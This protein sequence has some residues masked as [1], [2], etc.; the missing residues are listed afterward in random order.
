MTRTRRFSL[1][2]IVALAFCC[3]T[4][5]DADIISCSGPGYCSFDSGGYVSKLPTTTLE[6]DQWA[7]ASAS[8][9]DPFQLGNVFAEIQRDVAFD[10]YTLGPV[11]PGFLLLGFWAADQDGS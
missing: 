2:C 9:D 6:L 4:R 3:V 1:V 11:R 10:F 7:S 5:L 8:W